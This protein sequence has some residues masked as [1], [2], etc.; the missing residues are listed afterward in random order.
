MDV[1]N[2]VA[3]KEQVMAAKKD[4]EVNAN[5]PAMAEE[6]A[7]DP[8]RMARQ[9]SELERYEPGV[10]LS[11]PDSNLRCGWGSWQPKCLQR[12]NTAPWLLFC[13][14]FFAIIQGMAVNG[15]VNSSVSSLERRFEL[16]SSHLGLLPS[17]FDLIAAILLVMVGYCGARGNR[18]LWLALGLI[19]LAA[20]SFVFALPHFTT[21]LY[22]FTVSNQSG[23]CSHKTD[24][25]PAE[26]PVE[27]LPDTETSITSLSR[28]WYVFILANLFF[29]I[30]SAPVYSLG[31]AFIDE[32]VKMESVGLYIGIYAFCCALGPAIGF[33]LAGLILDKLFT[34]FIEIDQASLPIDSSNREWVGAWWLGFLLCSI[35]A[36]IIAVPMSCFPVELPE[37]K[38][39]RADRVSQA[40][41][42]SGAEIV[43]KADF[44]LT[45]RD[46]PTAT[47]LLLRN[48]TYML[49]NVALTADFIFLS[50]SE[51]FLPKFLESQFGVSSG[52]AS[53]IVG[54]IATVAGGGSVL[55]SGW[56]IKRFNMKIPGLLKLCIIA[57]AVD[58]ILMLG[59]LLRCEEIPLAGVFKNYQGN[60]S[61]SEIQ[62]ESSCN[63][64][65]E[66][67]T[68]FYL[69]VCG[70]N[71]MIYF[72]ACH[73]GCLNYD[74]KT[75]TY[76]DCL[77]T[78]LN[79]TGTG[80]A[81]PGL[82]PS[83]CGQLG[84]FIVFLTAII[85]AY[86]L[87]GVPAFNIMLRCV[88]D[89][90]QAYALGLHGFL[91]R[92]FGAIPGPI[93]FGYILDTTCTL[94][95]KE[96][97]E[98]GQCW[99]YNRTDVSVY[100]M[101]LGMIVKGVVFLF[102]CLALY[103]YRPI[104]SPDGTSKPNNDVYKQI[105]FDVET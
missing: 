87:S 45:W 100:V 66:C 68:E 53:L 88:P 69:P 52:D 78:S 21:D 65:C 38:K 83:T 30:A 6:T 60:G 28:Y 75:N 3:R 48:P 50:G 72:S 42:K 94:W 17:F 76:D 32:S 101:M 9:G 41:A 92:A 84:L 79:G 51:A 99:F 23:V 18:P 16:S 47:K 26:V 7:E 95:H 10:K 98:S 59:L 103:S 77:C 33:T 58:G 15:L 80:S 56:L 22:Q 24:E 37:T 35:L 85:I 8:A 13:I 39:L 44:G 73:A 82:C 36:L 12:F 31:P 91:V 1:L 71:G 61:L 14:C 19:S 29:G 97:E 40:H 96:C 67:S 27:C 86:F 25:N 63:L 11:Y 49:L 90:Q 70:E 4:F 5:S 74:D 81:T 2:G 93:L 89:G 43:S 105:P 55:F 64:A 34:D 57:T 20:G 102:H 46:M 62:L 54:V 104:S